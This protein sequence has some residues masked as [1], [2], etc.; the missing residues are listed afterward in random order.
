MPQGNPDP[1]WANAAAA[2][3][4]PTEEGNTQPYQPP[5]GQLPPGQLN[6][7]AMDAG[8]SPGQRMDQNPQ[9]PNQDPNRDPN[10]DPNQ[11]QPQYQDGQATQAP[12]DYRVE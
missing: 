8:L 10:Q 12:Q 9:D 6:N 1:N 2:G 5:E 7:V 3:G 4:V 11:G